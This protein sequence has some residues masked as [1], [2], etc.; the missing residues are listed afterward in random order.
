MSRSYIPLCPPFLGKEEADRITR[1]IG[2]NWV[3]TGGPAVAEFESAVASR[4]RAG[5]AVALNSGTSALAL[6]V[7]ALGIGP[8]DEVLVPTLTFIAPVNAI[9]Y[10]GAEPVFMDCDDFLNIDPE[11]I[12]SFLSE[13]CRPSGKRLVNKLSGRIVKA[14]LPVHVFGNPADMNSIMRIAGEYGL[15]VIEDAS[16][17]LGSYYSGGPLEGRHAGTVGHIGCL[18]FNANKI[19][20][21]GSGGMA[22]TGDKALASRIKYLAN[23]SKDD[24]V[25]YVHNEIGYNNGMNNIQAAMGLAQLER[26]GGFMEAKRRNFGL[27]RSRL[28]AVP[29]VRLLDEPPY[30]KSNLWF[31]ALAVEEGRIGL[32]ELVDKLEKESVQTRPIWR[33]NHLQK[34]YEKNESYKISRAQWF[35]DRVI[36]LPC[37]ASLTEEEIHRVCE[38]VGKVLG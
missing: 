12:A 15:L 24:G 21:T 7:R 4:I 32:R 30:A 29:G 17:S 14:V 13:R 19:I 3:S 8:G 38:A 18:S 11:K 33:L 9:R 6:A 22:V 31:Y 2:E 27:Y 37:G 10:A 35:Y 23:Q 28:D 20:T 34:P 5:H 36:N 25:F 1:A 16:E 26:L